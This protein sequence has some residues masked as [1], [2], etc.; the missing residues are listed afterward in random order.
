MEQCVTVIQVNVCLAV[1]WAEEAETEAVVPSLAV[2][3]IKSA[4]MQMRVIPS[5]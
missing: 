3:L 5:V 2:C 4:K 1:F